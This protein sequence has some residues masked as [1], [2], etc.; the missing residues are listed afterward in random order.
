MTCIDENASNKLNE[1][2]NHGCE[3]K[4]KLSYSRLTITPITVETGNPVLTGSV[5]DNSKISSVGQELGP[6][7]DLS[8][9]FDSN[10]GKTFSHEWDS[11]L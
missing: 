2:P 1:P 6:S 3:P 10:T 9:D 5:V 4:A 7:Y 8:S 11:N